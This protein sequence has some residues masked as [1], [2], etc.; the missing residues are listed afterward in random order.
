MERG[1]TNVSTI[2][3]V[4][5]EIL[6]ALLLAWR[7]RRRK[8]R[9]LV[10]TRQAGHFVVRH[11]E[12]AH[13]ALL[14]DEQA[15]SLFATVPFGTSPSFEL[16]RAV[17]NSFVIFELPAAKVV[18]RRVNVP[19]QAR[20][21][22]SGVVSN[23]IERLSPWPDSAMAYG[24][25]AEPAAADAAVIDVWVLMSARND[26]DAARHELDVLGL[27]LD[28][29]VARSPETEG[30]EPGAPVALWSRLMD[31]SP[32]GLGGAARAIGVGIAASVAVTLVV[33][34]WALISASS[35]RSESEDIAARSQALKQRAQAAQTASSL[36]RTP[37]AQR[38]WLL[39]NTSISS[40][41][42]I[43]ALSR[44]LPDSAYVSEIR[45]EKDSLHVTGLATDVPALL[46]PLERSEHMT[47]VH[48]AGPT[49]REPDGKLFRF[50]IEA[51][52]EP[53]IR[54][55]EH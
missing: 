35:Y 51:H 3:R 31:T 30:E 23:Q 10:V 49:A 29:I 7:D 2:L 42:L 48:F 36:A 14:R 41:I 17:R 45:L 50:T 38:I 1:V 16:R 8:R 12:P 24:F 44:A 21:F 20:N 19:A 11:A 39:K 55:E 6:A 18:T 54:I 22:L 53:R 52:V 26:I 4:W 5:I 15:E 47:N 32:D 40:V 28:Q 34:S 43:E 27:P 13:D 46:A 25:V 37:P 9:S 33:A